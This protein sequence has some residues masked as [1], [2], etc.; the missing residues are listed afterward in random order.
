MC[1]SKED[2]PKAA[3]DKNETI[4]VIADVKDFRSLGVTDVVDK[5][6]VKIGKYIIRLIKRVLKLDIKGRCNYE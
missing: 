1:L 3:F 5:G 2:A 4:P 6:G